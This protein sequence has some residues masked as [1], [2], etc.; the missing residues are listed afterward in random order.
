[1]QKRKVELGMT[2]CSTPACNATRYQSWSP[3]K[4]RDPPAREAAQGGD[5]DTVLGKLGP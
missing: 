1:M 2:V 4:Q 5:A 3:S